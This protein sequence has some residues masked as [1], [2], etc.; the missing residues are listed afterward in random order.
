LEF[1]LHRCFLISLLFFRPLRSEEKTLLQAKAELEEKG[2][3]YEKVAK[4]I[5]TGNT[6]DKTDKRFVS[7]PLCLPFSFDFSIIVF[8]F[9]LL[10]S[11]GTDRMKKLI[12]Q[13]KADKTIRKD[14]NKDQ[15]A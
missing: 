5:N 14:S 12:G 3:I 7:R 13:L 10:P 8:P 2:T 15:K 1:A 4:L 6:T 11:Y 9:L